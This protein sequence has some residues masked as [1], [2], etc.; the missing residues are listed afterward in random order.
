MGGFLFAFFLVLIGISSAKSKS[1]MHLFFVILSALRRLNFSSSLDTYWRLCIT[2]SFS[3]RL[4]DT[5]PADL[6]PWLL[7]SRWAF[8]S[9][10]PLALLILMAS[11][12]RF[13]RG[14]IQSSRL[15]SLIFL[16]NTFELNMGSQC[17]YRLMLWAP[18]NAAPRRR[19]DASS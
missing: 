3:P 19:S 2:P 4:L 10:S 15:G 17:C 14:S 5:I 11:S 9:T 1:A 7:C 6:T 12:W 13:F 16:P 8:S 18:D